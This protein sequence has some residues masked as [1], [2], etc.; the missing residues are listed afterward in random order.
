MQLPTKST[1][2]VPGL[3]LLATTLCLSGPRPA[4]AT[5]Y[6][7]TILGDN[8]VVFYRLNEAQG[9][10]VAADSSASGQYPGNYNYSA[11]SL[12]PILDEPG[13]DSNSILLSVAEPSTVTS[14]YYDILNQQAPFSVEIWARPTSL[15]LVNYRCPVGNFSGWGVA[16]VSGWYIYQTPGST[17]SFVWVTPGGGWIQSSTLPILDWYH[18]VATFDGTNVSFYING[19][20]IGTQNESATFVANSVNNPSVNSVSLGSRGDSS[21]YGAFD[22]GLDDFAY[23]TNV[24]TAGQILTHYQ[25]GTNSFRATPVAPSI[26]TEDESATNYAGTT[27]QFS[28]IADGTA[29]LVYQWYQ[30]SSPIPGATG[31]VLSFTC[32]PAENG[33]T[34]SVVITNTVGAV[35]SSVVSLTVSTNL[36][37][38]GPPTSITRNVGSA[39]AFEV[40]AEGAQP[41]TYQWYDNGTPIPGATNTLLWLYNL[42]STNDGAAYTVAL[43]DP[44]LSVTS[45]PAVLSV[46]ARPV[47]V[48][49]TTYAQ[50]VVAD[51]PVA[52]WRLNE[53]SG[54]T[55]A[56]DA[57]GSFDGSYAQ[58]NG[59]GNFTFGVPTGVPN[60][61]D[62]AVGITNGAEISIPY[63]IELNSPSAFSVEGWFQPASLAAN[64]N[65]YRTPLSSMSNPYGAGPT[66]WLVYQ[67]AQNNWAWWPYA[68]FWDEASFT[69]PETIVAGKWYY[70][71]LT[72]DGTTFTFYVNGVA[73]ASGAYS[74]FVQNGDVPAGGAASYNY[75]YNT[76][77]GLPTGSSP[78]IIGWRSDIDFNP[79]DGNVDEVAV[80]NKALTAQQIQNHFL[81]TTHL[82]AV[83]SGN[84]IVVTWGAGTLQT[85][86]SLAGPYVSVSGAT[87]P[88]TNAISGPIRFY[89]AQLQ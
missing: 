62:A 51:G 42:Q 36:L 54:A 16:S 34:Y 79:F 40:V 1:S 48:P 18:L 52:Y 25:V 75:N 72:Y 60:D 88:Y 71:V 47:T 10:T 59:T 80:Y 67:T 32:T 8:P 26:L 39:A 74:S 35:T 12:Y 57:V 81:N 87:S 28:V 53:T 3:F 68:G 44:Y 43:T 86:T 31:S 14:G 89:R 7:T 37:I 19:A 13:I 20:L 64:G 73:Q 46:Q 65:D 77:T 56:T 61:T 21:G 30:G 76:G 9:A 70:L 29:P 11:N 27:A 38:N 58:G 15:D 84:N 4:Q 78:M 23:Y 63:A 33:N 22:G 2:A 24:L 55:T 45:S 49:I 6:P 17:M 50:V 85:A 5:D 66:G 82:S 83:M 41:I 69:D